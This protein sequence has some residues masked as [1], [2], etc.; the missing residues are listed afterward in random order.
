MTDFLTTLSSCKSCYW[1]IFFTGHAG[2]EIAVIEA[3]DADSG[4]FGK[5]TY[6]LDRMSSQVTVNLLR[7]SG[8]FMY[9]KV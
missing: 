1:F 3:R 5:V 2:T 9:H 6:L 8:F 7:P 4:D